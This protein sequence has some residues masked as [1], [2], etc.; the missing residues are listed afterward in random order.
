MK[1]TTTTTTMQT[2]F[3]TN[4]NLSLRKVAQ[5]FDVN[6]NMLLKA[7][8]TPKVGEIYDPTAMNFE[9]MEQ[10]LTKKGCD[11]A[12]IDWNDV[13]EFATTIRVQLPK[14]FAEGQLIQIR[15]DDTIY[16]I[17]MLT[18][19]HVVIMGIESTQ[20]R[21]MSLPTFMHQGPKNV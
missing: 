12:K 14:E 16:K 19:T 15:Q 13:S 2:A 7:A 17:H 1:T 10:Y 4:E 3:E 21:V 11:L 6:Y 18:E 9:A 20:P 8:K 5:Y